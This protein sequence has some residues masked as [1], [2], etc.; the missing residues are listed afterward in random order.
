MSDGHELPRW[1][2]LALLPALNL[3]LA[4]LVAGLVLW[5]VGLDPWQVLGLLIRGAFGSQLG[6]GY[7]LYYATTFVFAALAVSVAFHGGL[8]NIGSEGQ[9]ILGGLGAGVV[10]LST[11]MIGAATGPGLPSNRPS[12]SAPAPATAGAVCQSTRRCHQRSRG[13]DADFD[14]APPRRLSMRCQTMGGATTGSM[15]AVCGAAA[16][17]AK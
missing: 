7:T 13:A 10:A 16:V 3:A 11:T 17:A 4:L 6:I 8:F 15:L 2:D 14:G 5:G 9:A 12:A 1:M